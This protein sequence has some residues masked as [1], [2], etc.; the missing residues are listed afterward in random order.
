MRALF[1]TE[2]LSPSTQ[3]G[4][5]AAANAEEILACLQA[6]NI[7]AAN[8]ANLTGFALSQPLTEFISGA[9]AEDREQLAPLMD[10]LFPSIPVGDSFT[11]LVEDETQANLA[12]AAVDVKRAIGGDFSIDTPK[13]TQTSGQLDHYGLGMY[14]DV[15]QGAANPRVQ[16]H[17]AQVLRNRL[18]RSMIAE[19]LGLLTANAVADTGVN[20]NA[21][22]ADP[23]SDV[24]DMVD[25]AGDLS[26]MNCNRVIYGGGAWIK[27]RK[28]YRKASRT[29]GGQNAN[30]TPEQLALESGLDDVIVVNSRKRSSAAALAK[31]LNNTV[32]AY[33]ASSSMLPTDSS[34][35]KRFVG[36]GAFGDLQVFIDTSSPIRTKIIVHGMALLKVTRATGIRSRAITYS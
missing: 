24:D 15:R 16:Q 7:H 22:D 27:R 25:A 10:R 9:G 11:Y 12:P 28:A 14:I 33:D 35:I 34:N 17:Y 8:D 36:A 13:G 18:L 2:I 31:V 21:A 3:S 5:I 32:I 6:G 20:W 1:P 29:N 23:D 30:I 19:G 4:V 26:G